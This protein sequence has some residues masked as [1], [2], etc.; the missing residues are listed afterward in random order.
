M[1][2]KLENL[3]PFVERDVAVS[4]F[5]RERSAPWNALI[6]TGLKI[7]HFNAPW[8][9]KWHYGLHS[10]SLSSPFWNKRCTVLELMWSTC[11]K[12]YEYIKYSSYG[13]ERSQV[14]DGEKRRPVDKGSR[15]QYTKQAVSSVE[16]GW[17][18]IF[19]FGPLYKIMLW[20]DKLGLWPWRK[21]KLR[22]MSASKMEKVIDEWRK[23]HN[24][25]LPGNT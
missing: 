14:D 12:L 13:M 19:R 2:L 3:Q 24:E 17:S 1:P 21:S 11:L 18:S 7:R 16:K 20:S 4:Q 8:L 10:V 23:L 6:T 22:K 9:T 25:Y 5:E 15:C